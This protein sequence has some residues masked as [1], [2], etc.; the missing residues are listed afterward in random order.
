MR[1]GIDTSELEERPTGVGTYT[2]ALIKRW[3]QAEDVELV[4]FGRRSTPQLDRWKKQGA[5]IRTRASRLPSRPIVWQQLTLPSL[6]NAAELDVFFGPAYS[7]PWRLRPPSVVAIHDLS[8]ERF[9]SAYSRKEGMRRR[10]LA[11]RAARRA[12]HILTISQFSAREIEELYTVAG[13]RIS[14]IPLAAERRKRPGSAAVDETLR[15]LGI[16]RPYL[17]HVGTLFERRH[18]PELVAA[19]SR[20][21]RDDLRLVIV[22]ENRTN[23]PLDLAALAKGLD[24]PHHLVHQPYVDSSQLL[25]LYAGAEMLISLSEYEGFGLPV[26]E[27]LQIGTPVVAL[28]RSAASEL[29]SDHAAMVSSL[30]PDTVAD[31]ILSVLDEPERGLRNFEQLPARFDWDQTAAETL[32]ILRRTANA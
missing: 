21:D 17:L 15:E 3:L 26:L 16:E 30:D 1:L 13:D 25:A 27:C 9:R 10:F 2:G 12:R 8:F 5:D 24:A 31:V 23:P 28:D 7:L 20:V 18:I 4:L 11:R 32:A 19:F 14:A 6:A 29:W 22:G